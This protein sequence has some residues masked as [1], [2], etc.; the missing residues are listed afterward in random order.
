M[1]WQPEHGTQNMAIIGL[2]S[3][4][5]FFVNLGVVSFRIAVDSMYGYN[6][7]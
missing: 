6:I 2:M 5:G 3:D 4:N 7:Q 1:V